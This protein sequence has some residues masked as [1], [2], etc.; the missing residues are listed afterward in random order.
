MDPRTRQ[1]LHDPI[2]PT[3]IR[4]AIPSTLVIVAQLLAGLIETWYVS[5][6]GTD[7]LAAMA[8][9]FPVLMLMQM[10]S[11]GAMGGGISSAIARA[12]GAGESHKAQALFFHAMLIALAL[13][14]LCTLALVGGGPWLYAWMGGTGTSVQLAL[15]YSNWLFSGTVLIW[16]FNALVSVVRGCG[17]MWVP[18]RVIMVGTALVCGVSPVLIWGW[19]TWPG[20]GMLGGAWVLLV[21]YAAGSLVLLAYLASPRSLLRPS[22]QDAR[23]QSTLFKQILGVG[24]AAM[25]S[26]A[27]TNIAIAT[28]TSL[29]GQLGPEVLAGYGTSARL[30][31]I[32][33][34]LVFGLGSPLV[35]MVG[36][37]IGAGQ[38]ERALKATWIGA[39]MAFGI[40]ESIGL[41]ATAFPQV[42]IHVFTADEAVVAAGTHYLRWVGPCYGFFGLG[43]VLYFAS[44]GAGKMLWPVLGNLLRLLL[45]A[46]GGW[47][48][49]SWGGGMDG[50][51]FFQALGLLAYGVLVTWAVRRG[52]WFRP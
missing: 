32:M 45:A 36:T 44:Q 43:L 24:L 42:W 2:A 29:M 9:V 40:T 3:L 48:A 18:A 50:V 17:N 23:W 21:Y 11:S 46:A 1:L 28:A 33:V 47:C 31:Y 51:F 10:M 16:I 14:L 27:C 15:S 5:R 4:L 13:G 35:A 34:S 6:L 20:V 8:L 19:G 52:V 7:A 39:A 25:V 22:W 37:S 38:P 49:W 12:L 26:A 41:L 30:E